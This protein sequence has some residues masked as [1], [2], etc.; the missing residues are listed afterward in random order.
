MRIELG[1]SAPHPP[2]LPPRNRTIDT[3]EKVKPTGLH[4]VRLVHVR[5]VPDGRRPHHT[6]GDCSAVVGQS[7]NKT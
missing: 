1:V 2:P 3:C 5:R 4:T 6:A 7:V